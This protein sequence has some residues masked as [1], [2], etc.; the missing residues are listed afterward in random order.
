MA[1]SMPAQFW[2]K[3]PELARILSGYIHKEME[4]ID[5]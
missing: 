1:V 3:M 2:H 5:R 4:A